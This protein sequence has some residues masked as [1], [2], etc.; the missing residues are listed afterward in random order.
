MRDEE[1]CGVGEMRCDVDGRWIC[2][3]GGGVDDWWRGGVCVQ[4]TTTA[5]DRNS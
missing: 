4:S 1:G 5:R 3:L 2:G